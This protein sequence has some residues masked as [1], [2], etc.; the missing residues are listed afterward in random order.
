MRTV[1]LIFCIALLSSAAFA[2]SNDLVRAV[3]N[4]ISTEQLLNEFF[5]ESGT[6]RQEFEKYIDVAN[7]NLDGVPPYIKMLFGNEKMNIYIK[8][9]SG[10][11]EALG[12]ET[13][14]DKLYSANRTGFSG[15]TMNVYVSEL[16]L[17]EI[18]SSDN[19]KEAA[20]S[21]IKNRR[22]DYE[23]VG[24]FSSIKIGLAKFLQEIF[25]YFSR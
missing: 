23:G 17:K 14:H 6:L 20:I 16:A 22:I 21:A 18:I 1:C 5:D 3:A 2:V 13:R 11:T 12:I 19:P 7:Q 4:S 24:F 10:K 9:D 15:Q 8:L 25:F